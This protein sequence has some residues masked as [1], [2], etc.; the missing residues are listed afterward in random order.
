VIIDLDG[1][2]VDTAGVRVEAWQVAFAEFGLDPPV[3]EVAIRIGMDG[4]R[5]ARE[6]AS[7]CGRDVDEATAAEI[8]AA[9][10]RHFDALNTDPK[11]LPGAEE[12]IAELERQRIR[13]AVATSSQPEQVKRS[14]SRIQGA[15]NAVLIDA[16]RVSVAKPAPDGLLAAAAELRV[17]PS[18]C[19][20]IGDSI[21]DVQ[22]ARAAGMTAVVVTRGSVAGEAELRR[23]APDGVVNT[24]VDVAALLAA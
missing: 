14:L 5:L 20:A 12:L 10:G 17:D 18:T 1:T 23:A 9:A 24:L 2:L 22:A 11:P 3:G 15:R 16:S 8:D 13:W 21:W 7:L 6:V 4:R 19:W